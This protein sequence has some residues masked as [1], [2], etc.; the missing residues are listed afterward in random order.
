MDS[1]I[2][3]KQIN[4]TACWEEYSVIRRTSPFN[5]FL[6]L[7]HGCCSVVI[8]TWRFSVAAVIFH[9]LHFERTAQL[10]GCSCLRT[11]SPT[12]LAVSNDRRVN[13]NVRG[14]PALGQSRIEEELQEDVGGMTKNR[15]AFTKQESHIGG[16]LR[17][18]PPQDAKQ[19]GGFC[20]MKQVSLQ[21]T[22]T[23]LLNDVTLSTKP[24]LYMYYSCSCWCYIS[25][26]WNTHTRSPCRD[27]MWLRHAT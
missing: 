27:T 26:L 16:V 7:C 4:G 8:S 21:A 6:F 23:P 25:I 19:R 15:A 2:I 24:P 20:G 10:G 13:G 18:V 1:D 11:S 5:G 12:V 17:A 14:S 9:R 22:L 3:S